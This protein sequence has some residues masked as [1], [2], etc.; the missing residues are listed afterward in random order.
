MQQ[1]DVDHAVTTDFHGG[2]VSIA[3]LAVNDPLFEA[4][5][6]GETLDGHQRLVGRDLGRLRLF[7]RRH[8]PLA[9]CVR[10]TKR[11]VKGT[12]ASLSGCPEYVGHHLKSGLARSRDSQAS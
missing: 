11:P 2:Q 5:E 10:L 7:H 12:S 4:R 3:N 1:G 6:L 8:L 9:G